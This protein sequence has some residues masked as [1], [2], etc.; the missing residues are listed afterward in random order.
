MRQFVSLGCHIQ[1]TFKHYFISTLAQG[2]G[3]ASMNI[4]IASCAEASSPLLSECMMVSIMGAVV[5]WNLSRSVGFS[6]SCSD[7][8]LAA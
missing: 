5:D 7:Q 4:S 6:K 2:S 1:R 8:G 3:R